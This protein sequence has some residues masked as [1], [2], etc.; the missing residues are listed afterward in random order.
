MGDEISHGLGS[1][2]SKGLSAFDSSAM[3]RDLQASQQEWRRLAD[4][5]ADAARRMMRDL[6]QVEAAQRRLN[7]VTAKYGPESSRA[8]YATVGLADANARAAK[9]QR[10]HVDAM[11]AAEAAHGRLGKSAD[12]AGRSLTALQRAGSNPIINAAGIASVAGLG[13]ALVEAGRAAGDFQQQA[14]KL[15]A[16]AG[17]STA[18][19]KTW[20]DGV[21]KM[22][23]DVGYSSKELMNGAFIISKYG[24]N[25]A[26]G[27]TILK[28][29]AQGANAEQADLTEVVNA[30]TLSMHNF[31]A[32]PQEA[33]RVMSQMVAAVGEGKGTLNEFA[34]ALDAVEPMAHNLGLSLQDVWGTL[35]QISQ[36]GTSY[37]QGAQW[38]LNAMR[39]LSNP[40]GPA[41]DA[42]QQLGLNGDE[43]SQQLGGPNGR[44]LAGTMQYITDTVMKDFANGNKI[45]VGELRNAAQAQENLN[46]ML[47]QMSPYAR[48]NAQAL[49]NNTEGS[50]AYTMA[51]RQAN[52]QDKTQMGQARK[53]IDTIDG[54]SKRYSQGRSV[55]ESVTQALI[56]LFGTQE[57]AQVALQVTGDNA[58]KTNKKIQQIATTYTNAD[59][60]VKGFNESQDTL[61]AKMRDAK[62]AFGAAAIE[63]G[64]SFVPVMTDLAKGAKWVGDEFAKHPRIAHDVVDA[65]GIMGA[66]WLTFKAINITTSILSPIATG[67]GTVLGKL[68]G[69]ELQAG[70]AGTAMRRMGTAA[71]EGV[72]GV[73]AAA[74]EEVAAEGRVTQSALEADAA[75]S[76]GGRGFSRG[77]RGFFGAIPIVGPIA[78]TI[79]QGAEQL[80]PES[81]PEN[82]EGK[83]WGH[84]LF[85][86]SWDWITGH[87][88]G[89]PLRAPGPKGR[90][91]ALFWG[92]DGEHV[93]TH[94]DVQAAGGHA[95]VYAWRAGLHRQYG[96]PIGPDVQAAMAMEGA[97]YSQSDRTD[98][99]GMVG[100]VVLGALGIPGGSLPTT[101]NMGQWLSNLGFQPGIGGPGTI[102]VGWYNHGSAPNDG[103]AAMTL[104]DGENAESG[105]THGNFLVGAGAA[106]ASNPE[107]DHHMFLPNLYGEGAGGGF[108]GG[109]GGG[110]GGFGGGFG[111]FGGFGGAGVPAGA[112]AGTGPGGM[113]GYYTPNPQRVA[114]AQEQLRHLDAEIANAEERKSGLKKDAS[115]A[116]RDRLDEEIRHLKAERVQEQQRLAEAE[117]GTFHAGRGRGGM[118]SPFLPVPLANKFGLGKGLPGLAEWAV[119]FLEDLALGPME[120]AVMNAL[121]GAPGYGFRAGGPMMPSLARYSPPAAGGAGVAGPDWRGTGGT[122]AGGNDAASRAPGSPIPGMAETA[123][124]ARPGPVPGMDMVQAPVLDSLVGMPPDFVQFARTHPNLTLPPYKPPP[125]GQVGGAWGGPPAE[126]APPTAGQQW[127]LHP[128]PNSTPTLNLPK[129]WDT[130][131]DPWVHG[132]HQTQEG[133][134][135]VRDWFAHPLPG[136]WNAGHFA[137]GGPVGYF[138]GG[139]EVGDSE[140]EPN[141]MT[142]L[143]WVLT[144]LYGP[145]GPHS[146]AGHY[147]SPMHNATGGPVPRSGPGND[148]SG[149]GN[150]FDP[151][152]FIGWNYQS[153]KDPVWHSLIGSQ[154]PAH[155]A[156]GGPVGYFAKGGQV[157]PYIL[158][159]SEASRFRP[160][161]ISPWLDSNGLPTIKIPWGRGGPGGA[162]EAPAH[163]ATGG[164]SGTDTIASW[165]SPGEFVQQ[166]SAVDMY[167]EPFMDA[168]DHGRVDPSSIRYFSGGGSVDGFAQSPPPQ[169]PSP[170]KPPAPSK[171]VDTALKPQ[172]GQPVLKRGPDIHQQA[173]AAIPGGAQTR[174][175]LEQPGSAKEL[176]AQGQSSPGIGFGGGLLGAAEGAASQAA[177]MAASMGTFGGAGGAASSATQL[178]FQLLN[179]TAAYGAQGVGIGVEGLLETVLPSDSPLSDFGN[180]LPGKLISGIAGA[181]PAQPNTAGQTR[182]PLT[183]DE[184]QAGQQ[185]GVGGGNGMSFQIGSMTVHPTDLHDFVNQVSTQSQQQALYSAQARHPMRTP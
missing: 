9:S 80:N 78:M 180:T 69:I 21:L 99:S 28:A 172:P 157:N 7:E 70:T 139:G 54:F 48:E 184:A 63:I 15:H 129:L 124:G 88:G 22:T 161:Q 72:T 26:D 118:G 134:R 75:M 115:Q 160:A 152:G 57:A 132:W 94:E 35:A 165:L 87:A 89:G 19:L 18:D 56:Q 20:S 135:E 140:F 185:R 101:Q 81:N 106:G 176:F 3:R 76:G 97:K 62:A 53:L 13:V 116:E 159:D 46:G 47:A 144:Q 2:I 93:L 131:K 127:W 114:S 121:G 100:R 148:P 40:Q 96:G 110:A 113:P 170:P 171:G 24:Y 133:G 44:G 4:V 178:A 151:W 120:T 154:S 12:D 59:G 169:L 50:R 10:D 109:F 58:D 11:V 141:N 153:P 158:P 142:S 108:G 1:S 166:K 27:L 33:S 52:E 107:F 74:A 77:M 167:G 71:Q 91:S 60:T 182:A 61:N 117:Q 85:G 67:L 16:A 86:K 163:F 183:S 126:P 138:S 64:S 104:S 179:R 112:T 90:D 14:T 51:M 55:I 45:N 111:G 66:A 84:L 49:A 145:V 130:L 150:P 162:T 92:A 155:N 146:H 31:N 5:E 37:D 30:L 36:S 39:T 125:A 128:N 34:G 173:L 102:S 156:K 177:G 149:S 83:G 42:M 122:A 41:R 98:C 68:G 147:T 123:G 29:A 168:L 137:T 119:G 175:G 73:D 25:A 6:G 174:P 105:G 103:H 143:P 17:V 82:R 23:G 95:G 79:Q 65:V 32:T 181:R 164:P 8:A 136:P 43:I 38:M